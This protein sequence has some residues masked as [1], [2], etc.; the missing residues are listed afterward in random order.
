MHLQYADTARLGRGHA[1]AIGR[2]TG[3]KRVEK[4]L[5]RFRRFEKRGAISVI[6]C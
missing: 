4:L 3:P 5:E 2:S 6:R 1:L